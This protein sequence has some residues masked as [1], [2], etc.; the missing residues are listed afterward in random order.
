MG[1]VALPRQCGETAGEGRSVG[2]P[3][4]DE[5]AG[6]GGWKLGPPWGIHGQTAAGYGQWAGGLG[7]NPVS[8]RILGG[9]VGS[10]GAQGGWGEAG[11]TGKTLH[12]LSETA[13]EAAPL[14]LQGN[15]HPGSERSQVGS[16]GPQRGALPGASKGR[17]GGAGHAFGKER[18]PEP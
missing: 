10:P 18:S 11:A 14:G 5:R 16:V 2:L 12:Q 8:L 1:E 9:W 6:P 3:K 4:I 7:S 17:G 13:T 15:F